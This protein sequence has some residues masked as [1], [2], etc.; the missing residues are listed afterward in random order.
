MNRKDE[1]KEQIKTDSKYLK[2]VAKFEKEKKQIIKDHK[3]FENNTGKIEKKEIEKTQEFKDW[4]KEI[5]DQYNQQIND[6]KEELADQYILEKQAKLDDYQ[7]F[8][9][10]AE[11]IGYDATGKPTGNNELD[12]IESELKRFI[13]HVIKEENV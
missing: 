4:K 12:V 9:A 5:T 7:I 1:L 3:G 11:D 8:M 2:Q 10:I 13:A 6:L